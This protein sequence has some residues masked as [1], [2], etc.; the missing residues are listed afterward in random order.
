MKGP[1]GFSLIE[2]AIVLV[3]VTILIGGLAVPLSAQIEA[4]RIGETRKTMEEAREAIIGYTMSHTVNVSPPTTCTCVY[5]ADT[6]LNIVDA[7]VDTSDDPDSTCPTSLC[8]TTGGATLIVPTTRHFLPCPDIKSDPEPAVD[9]DGDGIQN[10]A[11][12]GREDR[13]LSGASI[14]DCVTASGNLPW[15]T[16]ATAAQDAWGNRLEY[17]LTAPFGNRTTGFSNTDNG[18]KQVCSS[19]TGTGCTMG[20]VAD[21]V[22][23]VLASY[24]PNGWGARNVNNNTL[25]APSSGDEQENT[26]ADTRF[27]SRSPTKAGVAA[28]EFDDLLTWISKSLLIS[29]VCPTPG[30]CP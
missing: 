22:P 24:G 6:T 13:Y 15:V 12:N 18:D 29:R 3:I 20:I 1:K 9:N 14:G 27:V 16:L 28:G 25:A 4:R 19:S 11:N 30:G 21:Q 2:L 10:D 8:P 26:D 23:V 17:A 7:P 5:K